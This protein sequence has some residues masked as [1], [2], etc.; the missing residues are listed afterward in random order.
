MEEIKVNLAER[1]HIDSNRADSPLKQAK[2]AILIDNTNLNREEQLAM[3]LALVDLRTK[4][5]I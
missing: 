4:D 1:D 3:V 2:D 5:E